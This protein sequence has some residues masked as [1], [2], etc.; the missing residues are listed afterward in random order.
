MSERGGRGTGSEDTTATAT[1]SASATPST[2][3]GSSSVSGGG[4]GSG[5][6]SST[7]S[8][9]S[10][11]SS[12]GSSAAQAAAAAVTT[13]SSVSGGSLPEA[14]SP[15]SQRPVTYGDKRAPRGEDRWSK[16]AAE[17]ALLA[18]QRRVEQERLRK[19]CRVTPWGT[20]F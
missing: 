7:S 16:M 17:A 10:V 20:C 12:S 2:A 1:A 18:K 13:G 8:G 5:G 15:L 19:V 11:G 14:K 6:R 3:A 4:S 9:A